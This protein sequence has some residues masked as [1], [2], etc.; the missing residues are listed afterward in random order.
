MA[1]L[2][3]GGLLGG[4]AIAQSAP[5]AAVSLCVDDNGRTWSTLKSGDC[6]PGLHLVRLATYDDL[7]E[8]PAMPGVSSPG[9]SRIHLFGPSGYTPCFESFLPG[10]HLSGWAWTGGCEENADPA[11]NPFY[12]EL[13]A[14]M[15]PASATAT[16][17]TVVDPSGEEIC[18]RLYDLTADAPVP[19]SLSCS[20]SADPVHIRT[21]FTLPDSPEPHRIVWQF[22]S[23]YTAQGSE[24]NETV[25]FGTA[26]QGA[27][28]VTW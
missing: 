18:T 8:D 1:V 21:E 26:R 27:I 24:G 7:A 11:S 13:H 2:V 23:T 5:P 14:A 4:I 15:F 17:I 3:V 10:S 22:R 28:E 9:Y 19:G 20:T 12:V 6:R 16:L 25:E